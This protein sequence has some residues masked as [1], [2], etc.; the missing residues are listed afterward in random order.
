MIVFCVSLADKTP[1]YV[2]WRK[3]RCWPDQLNG[4]NSELPLEFRSIAVLPSFTRSDKGLAYLGLF[5]LSL[6]ESIYL[7]KK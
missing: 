2:I 6:Y 3:I 1:Q 5:P 7:Y 4:L